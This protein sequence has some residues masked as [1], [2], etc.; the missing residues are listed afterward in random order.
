MNASGIIIFVLL[1]ITYIQYYHVIKQT[2]KEYFLSD[3]PEWKSNS[4]S[5]KSSRS[6]KFRANPAAELHPD[7]DTPDDE[8]SNYMFEREYFTL[9]EGLNEGDV[10]ECAGKTSKYKIEN[11]KRR[12]FT[13]KVY[14]SWKCPRAK[15][16]PCEILEEIPEG[17][18]MKL[19]ELTKPKKNNI[20]TFLDE[21][22]RYVISRNN[23]KRKMNKTAAVYNS[24]GKSSPKHISCKELNEISTGPVLSSKYFS[25]ETINRDRARRE[26]PGFPDYVSTAVCD[27]WRKPIPRLVSCSNKIMSSNSMVSQRTNMY[28]REGYT[29]RPYNNMRPYP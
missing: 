14:E 2:I 26:A 10:I 28:Y 29:R 12:R 1:I 11:G 8:S 17:P 19:K 18:N 16:V 21:D 25:T 9:P 20:A 5:I 13:A 7:S 22:E 27:S 15:L 4:A 24:W 23:I 6:S 3:E